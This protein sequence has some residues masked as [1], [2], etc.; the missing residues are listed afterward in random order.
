MQIKSYFSETFYNFVSF[1]I[2][3]MW[4]TTWKKTEE[5]EI[6]KRNIYSRKKT[7]LKYHVRKYYLYYEYKIVSV[8]KC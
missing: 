6:L 2:L 1:N 5:A 3:I 7:T 4:W 8:N